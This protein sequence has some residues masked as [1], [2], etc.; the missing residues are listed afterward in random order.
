MA[1][2]LYEAMEDRALRGD[3]RAGHAR[4]RRQHRRQDRGRSRAEGLR[5]DPRRVGRAARDGGGLPDPPARDRARSARRRSER[6]RPLARVHRG[7]RAAARS[8]T[9]RRSSTIRRPSPASRGRSSSDLGYGDQLGDDPDAGE[10][11]EDEAQDGPEERGEPR[12]AGRGGRRER[13]ERGR[14]RAVPG[15]AEGPGPRRRSRRTNWPMPSLERKPKL[16]EGE[17][18]LEPPPPAPESEADPNYVVYCGDFDEEIR[19]EDLAEPAELERLRAYLD[20]QLEPLKGAVSRLANK[21]QRRLQAQQNRSWEFDR[22]EGILDAGRLAR[23]VGEP[24]DAPVVQG[25]EG[26]RVPRH[27][28]DAPP[29]QLGLDAG[30]PDLHRR[31]LRRRPGPH[32]RTLPGEGRDPGLHHPRLEGRAGAREVA[33]RRPPARHPGGSTTCATSSTRPPTRPGGGRATTSA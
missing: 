19:A 9:S 29:R 10:D 7:F 12:L 5:P 3:R 27:G 24:D 25:R 17:A 26:H 4:H 31:D 18:P 2:D 6:A 13:R 20:Q 32:A 15:P 1:R 16:P 11:E 14:A 22:E 23:V 21:L 30:P 28:G 8:T 33:G